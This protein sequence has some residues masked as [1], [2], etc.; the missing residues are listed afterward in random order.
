M[1]VVDR[2][3]IFFEHLDRKDFYKYVGGYIFLVILLSSAIMYRYYAQLN[4]LNS[5]VE[6]LNEQRDKVRRMISSSERVQKQRV[7]VDNLLAKEE[8]FKIGGYFENILAKLNLKNNK[9]VGD[10]SHIDHKNNYRESILKVRL[11]DLDMKQLTELLKELALNKRIFIKEL[12]ITASKKKHKKIDVSLTIA[13]LE[14]KP[15]ST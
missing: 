7:E 13:T 12:E 14:I 10:H 9:T 6:E 8:D 2:L 11:I 3:Y 4:T 15:T 1:V 5:A